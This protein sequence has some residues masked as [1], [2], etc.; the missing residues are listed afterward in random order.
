MT[1]TSPAA[2]VI[3]RAL[4]DALRASARILERALSDIEKAEKSRAT[5]AAI[6][7]PASKSN[8]ETPPSRPRRLV[9]VADASRILQVSRSTIYRLISDRDLPVVKIGRSTRIEEEAL[10]RLIDPTR[11]P[12]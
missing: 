1:D 7:S 3:L 9:T 11:R 12:G 8:A 5:Q 4:V 2:K 6:R 10:E